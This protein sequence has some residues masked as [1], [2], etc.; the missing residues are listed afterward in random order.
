[1]A[2]ARAGWERKLYIGTAGSTAA[3]QLTQ[4]V[5]D[6]D[7]QKPKER[8]STTDRG[9]G[10]AV[11]RE[12]QQVVGRSA[13]VKWKQRYYDSD[14]NLNTIIAA[15]ES[16]AGLAIKVERYDSGEVEFDGDCTID[17]NSP[18]PIAGGMEIE[19]TAIPTKD[20]GR[21]WAD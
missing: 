21:E 11:P 4:G 10:S 20:Y 18:G 14:S 8:A 16:G 6:V 5:T 9:D 17:M 12:H 2:K 7:V 3:T 13:E 15:A 19:F 1:M